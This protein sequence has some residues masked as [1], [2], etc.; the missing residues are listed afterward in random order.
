MNDVA[1]AVENKT[2]LL[3]LLL[4]LQLHLIAKD[5]SIV[6]THSQQQRLTT[7][8]TKISRKQSS[9]SPKNRVINPALFLSASAEHLHPI[10]IRSQAAVATW[11]EDAKNLQNVKVAYGVLPCLWHGPYLKSMKISVQAMHNLYH[12]VKATSYKSY[13]S[14]YESNIRS[15]EETLDPSVNSKLTN[16]VQHSLIYSQTSQNGSQYKKSSPRSKTE[17]LFAHSYYYGLLLSKSPAKF[18]LC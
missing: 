6:Y 13:W 15:L 5:N 12:H 17:L 1:A 10:K 9:C 3:L 11:T 2:L 7:S 8:K 14:V 18:L 16:G 4:L